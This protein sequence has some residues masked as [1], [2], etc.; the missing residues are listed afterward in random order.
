MKKT[1][2]EE[3]IWLFENTVLTREQIAKRVVITEEQVDQF[4]L[5]EYQ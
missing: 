4:L 3:V 1:K 5:E 2:K